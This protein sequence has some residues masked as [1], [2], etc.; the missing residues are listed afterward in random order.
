[1]IYINPGNYPPLEV[2]NELNTESFNESFKISEEKRKKSEMKTKLESLQ[3]E[4]FEADETEDV[5]LIR[6][7][8]YY[9]GKN[10]LSERTDNDN[11]KTMKKKN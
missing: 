6:P 11:S 10:Y 3:I 2:I 7:Q 8:Y 5:N 1:M 9:Q 4:L